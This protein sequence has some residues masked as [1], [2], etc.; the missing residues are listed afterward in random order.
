MVNAD[1]VA[2]DGHKNVGVINAGSRRK[3]TPH[4]HRLLAANR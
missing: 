4:A 1:V 2:D 3:D